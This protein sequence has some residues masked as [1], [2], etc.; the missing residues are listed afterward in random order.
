MSV[1]IRD[2]NALRA[3]SPAALSAYARAAGWRK[4]ESYGDHSDVYTADER[5][6]V[7]VPRTERLGDYPRVVSQLIEI[8]AKVARRDELALY[9]DLVTADRDVV[10]VRVAESDDGSLTVN[11]G[12]ELIGGARDMLLSAACSLREPQPHYRTGANRMANA[13]LKQVRLGQTDQGSFVVTLLTPPVEPPSMP[14][15][16]Q[17]LGDWDAPIER[18]MTKRLVEALSATREATERTT[19]G[20][21]NAFADAMSSGVSANFCEA[22][23]RL[24]GPFPMLDVGVS[25]ARTR[26]LASAR[27]A[28]RFAEADS[29]I[30]REAALAFRE[31]TPQPDVYL[32]DFI[33]RGF[34]QLLK[35]GRTQGDGTI[36][37]TTSIRGRKQSVAMVLEPSDYEKAVRAHANRA[38]VV[39]AGDLE[40]MRQRWR[41]L[42]PRLT[43]IIRG[44]MP[45]AD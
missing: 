25:W 14:S 32:R 37:L 38:L 31:R 29:P 26:P 35:R 28:I 3:V 22:L 13:V 17:D 1:D 19:R 24:I 2:R 42:N 7:I 9:R 15:L 4:V 27:K 44:D 16:E 30:L 21:E 18:K 34:V 41:L 23:V 20:D 43:D 5:P 39:L 12:I 11:D 10:R 36:T 40:R 33:L 45:E 8:F 6:E